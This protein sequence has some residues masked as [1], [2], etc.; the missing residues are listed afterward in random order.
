MAAREDAGKHGEDEGGETTANDDD[1][2]GVAMGGASWWSP[3]GGPSS[4]SVGGP[5]LVTSSLMRTM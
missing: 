4:R 3:L 1:M 2:G 5:K